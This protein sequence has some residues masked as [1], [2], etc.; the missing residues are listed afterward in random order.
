M[1]MMLYKAPVSQ[2]NAGAKWGR[3][4]VYAVEGDSLSGTK[5]LAAINGELFAKTFS[6]SPGESSTKKL[7]NAENSMLNFKFQRGPNG[8]RP[9]SHPV[10]ECE[11]QHKL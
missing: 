3:F 10:N 5:T 7:K 2:W 9:V 8:F 6:E 11:I 4:F 1:L